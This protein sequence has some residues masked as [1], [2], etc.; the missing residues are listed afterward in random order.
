MELVD[1]MRVAR[2]TRPA[3]MAEAHVHSEVEVNLVTEGRMNY[4]FGGHVHALEGGELGV[5][6]GTVPHRTIGLAEPTRYVC[7]YLPIQG[8]LAI[9]AGEAFR[10]AVLAGHLLV[11][12]GTDELDRSLFL[13]WHRDLEEPDPRRRELVRDELMARLRRVDMEGWR[14][15]SATAVAEPPPEARR[16]AKAQRMASYIALHLGED[17]YMRD[18]AAAVHLHPNY[19]M[20]LFK[21]CLGLTV[22]QYVIRQRLSHAQAMLLSSD[23]DVTG[24]AFDCGFGSLSRFYEAFQEAFRTTPRDFRLRHRVPPGI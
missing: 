11:A 21:D 17:L 10:K 14:D 6:W 2:S 24:I 12:R 4:L 20:S 22:R 5:F 9:P 7:L 23:R 15:L 16:L 3:L 13:R 1:I 8:F 18:I 19:A